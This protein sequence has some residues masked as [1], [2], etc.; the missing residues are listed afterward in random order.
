MATATLEPIQSDTIYPLAII[1]ARLGLG[2]AALRTA[3][4]K[5]LKIRRL[6]RRSF[7]LGAD[8]RAYLEE[9]AKLVP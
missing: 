9:H 3:R 5:G 6:G 1:K 8:V 2:S 4:R 7:V